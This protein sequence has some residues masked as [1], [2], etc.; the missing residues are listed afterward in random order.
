MI[1]TLGTTPALQRTMSFTS[2]QTNQV[3]RAIEVHEFASG[4]S[5]NVSR[6]VKALGGITF[7]RGVAGGQRGTALLDDLERS[8]I[9]HDFVWVGAQT[10]M[11]TTLLDQATGAATELIEEAGSLSP[12]EVEILL[13][14]MPPP[15]EA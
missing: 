10:R 15:L 5:I 6:V 1:V 3:N 11:C 9:P 4:K 12:E 13:D 7:A 14:Q 8:D 2:L